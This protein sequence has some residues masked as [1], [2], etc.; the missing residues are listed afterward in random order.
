MNRE[1]ISLGAATVASAVAEALAVAVLPEV[2]ENAL[3]KAVL[4][5]REIPT[6]GRIALKI[7]WGK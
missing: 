7:S 2:K 5:S 3:V 6:R 1:R 4:P